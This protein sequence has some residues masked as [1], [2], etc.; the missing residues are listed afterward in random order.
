MWHLLIDQKSNLVCKKCYQLSKS[1]LSLLMNYLE[2]FAKL[3]MAKNR[4]NLL[5]S[6][7]ILGHLWFRKSDL[8]N[9][10]GHKT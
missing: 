7:F 6:I 4:E 1:S 9:E 10:I 5:L 8:A 3:E 2:Q